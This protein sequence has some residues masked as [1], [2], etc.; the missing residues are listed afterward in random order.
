MLHYFH[1]LAARNLPGGGVGPEGTAEEQ[2]V[3][4]RPVELV[5]RPTTALCHAEAAPLIL[6]K[7]PF[8]LRELV[9]LFRHGLRQDHMTIFIPIVLVLLRILDLV[10]VV[11]HC[12]GRSLFSLPRVTRLLGPGL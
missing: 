7:E 4:L 12:D 5:V 3:R 9:H 2:D 6:L 10:W 1:A 8:P 11:R